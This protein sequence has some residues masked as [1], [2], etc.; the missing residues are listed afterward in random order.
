MSLHIWHS[1]HFGKFDS[2]Y[3]AMYY[4]ASATESGTNLLTDVSPPG[5]AALPC[6]CASFT[7]V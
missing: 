4:K 5:Y 3:I 2:Q 7:R 6:L 1:V